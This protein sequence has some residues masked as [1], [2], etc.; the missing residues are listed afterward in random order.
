MVS[1]P[2]SEDSCISLHNVD[3]NNQDRSNPNPNTHDTNFI[4]NAPIINAPRQAHGTDSLQYQPPGVPVGAYIQTKNSQIL[5]FDG[6]NFRLLITPTQVLISKVGFDVTTATPDQFIFNSSQDMFKVV[7]SG[8]ITNIV[9]GTLAS[10]ITNTVSVA[11]GLSFTPSVLGFI[12]GTGSSYLVAGT[13]YQT[14]Y[15]VT[16]ALPG[17]VP[18]ILNYNFTVDATKVNTNIYNMG[19]VGIASIGTTVFKYYLLQETAN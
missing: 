17:G 5:T 3:K 18:E 9:S 8:T 19:G 7:G 13:N 12:S 6:T 1:L 10:G 4:T 16:A 2:G 15:L 14:P 11:H